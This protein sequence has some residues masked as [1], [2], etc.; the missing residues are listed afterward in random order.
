MIIRDVI[1]F[2]PYAG[3]CSKHLI[4]INTFILK[5]ALGNKQYINI[6]I[7]G[8]KKLQLGEMKRSLW[9]FFNHLALLFPDKC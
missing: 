4:Y 1:D 6:L 9:I 3:G 7:L 5:T 8:I 2:L